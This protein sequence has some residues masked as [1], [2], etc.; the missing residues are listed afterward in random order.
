MY[1]PS[2][3]E[4]ALLRY[5]FA[6]RD[7]NGKA[8]WQ[9]SRTLSTRSKHLF[10]TCPVLPSTPSTG[11]LQER[12]ALSTVLGNDKLLS[13]QHH[14]HNLKPY[15]RAGSQGHNPPE[16][17]TVNR[18]L[19]YIYASSSSGVSTLYCIVSRHLLKPISLKKRD[20]RTKKKREAPQK[21]Y[22]KKKVSTKKN[23]TN[24]HRTKI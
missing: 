18:L 3:P 21:I 19:I 1:A 14:L 20:H 15:T 13:S 5:Y 6:Y 8:G 2:E 17:K 12:A 7:S 23:H 22:A 4:N 11:M 9:Y 16:P 24:Q 10:S